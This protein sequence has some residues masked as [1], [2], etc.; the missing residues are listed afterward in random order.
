[1]DNILYIFALI[2][3]VVGFG[4]IIISLKRKKNF[5]KTKTTIKQDINSTPVNIDRNNSIIVEK[6]DTAGHNPWLYLS[7]H[8]KTSKKC[9]SP[10]AWPLKCWK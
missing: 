5:N 7:K 1:M 10:A 8:L 4:L 2:I 9:A 6:T 3:I